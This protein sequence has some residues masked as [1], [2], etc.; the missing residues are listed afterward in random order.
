MHQNDTQDSTDR[1]ELRVTLL[2]AFAAAVR[3]GTGEKSLWP[4]YRVL[5]ANHLRLENYLDRILRLCAALGDDHPNAIKL[6][7]F[8]Q[9]EGF[10]NQ[11]EDTFNLIPRSGTALN[12]RECAYLASVLKAPTLA[13]YVSGYEWSLIQTEQAPKAPAPTR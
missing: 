12:R 2:P 11:L 6:K 7:K 8:L 1:Y 10:K 9:D 13:R 5:N 3:N 4:L